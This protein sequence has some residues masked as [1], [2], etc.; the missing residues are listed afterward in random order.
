MPSSDRNSADSS[1][2]RRSS[3][4]TVGVALFVFGL[5]R[6]PSAIR[7][8]GWISAATVAG[9]AVVAVL[10]AG[11]TAFTVRSDLSNGSRQ[12]R[13]AVNVLN[14][15]D[16]EQ[17]A[18]GFR[19]AA[20]SFDSVDRRLANPLGK[21][22][23]IV[24]GVAQNVSAGA[25]LAAAAGG[26]LDDVAGALEQVDAETL[27]VVDGAIDV[28]AIS[29]VEAPLVQVQNSLADLRQVTADVQSPWLLGRIQSEL[30]DLT[31]EFDENEPRLQNAVDA[32]RLAPQILGADGTRRYLDPVHVARRSPRAHRIHR[33]LRR[34]RDR[35]RPDRGHRLRPPIR[36]PGGRQCHRH[37]RVH[38][39][40]RRDA[41]PL[42]T[43]RHRPRR[44]HLRAR[45]RGRP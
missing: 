16:Y 44:R 18:V 23:L 5:R 1:G 26:A 28:D 8:I 7:R 45:R 38:R 33:Q 24:P 9:V 3:A 36:P 22:A 30:A 41:R 25:D 42:R 40:P 6:R 32:V 10:A 31:K 14:D 4:I 29:A 20:N 43:V 39:L 11:W 13:H 19:S 35:Q 2:C 27:R 21:L 34:R 17:A 15:G 37:R 12:A